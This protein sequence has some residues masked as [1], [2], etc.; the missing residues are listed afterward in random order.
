MK[1]NWC[2]GTGIRSDDI[3]EHCLNGELTDPPFGPTLSFRD[4]PNSELDI[5][6]NKDFDKIIDY[7]KR[8]IYQ[9]IEY[10]SYYLLKYQILDSEE[11]NKF[12]EYWDSPYRNENLGQFLNRVAWLVKQKAFP[13]LDT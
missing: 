5:F 10:V 12:K 1:C 8:D 7:T 11:I 9:Q 13:H 3:C 4:I 6:T 2:N